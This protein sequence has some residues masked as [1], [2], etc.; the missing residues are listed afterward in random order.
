MNTKNVARGMASKLQRALLAGLVIIVL[1]GSMPV[2]RAKASSA[3]GLIQTSVTCLKGYYRF[4]PGF[5]PT[6][7]GQWVYFRLW[8]L[9][10]ATGIY[11]PTGWA[12][13]RAYANSPSGF[14]D[15]SAPS[16]TII[17]IITEAY[18][19]NATTS[20]WEYAGRAYAKHWQMTVFD[21]NLNYCRIY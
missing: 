5:V 12:Y 3:V 8:L 6:Y 19:Y 4:N 1:F 21:N 14:H 20:S 2:G 16:G 18:F 17:S 15:F 7:E 13:L 11:Q 9:D 10:S